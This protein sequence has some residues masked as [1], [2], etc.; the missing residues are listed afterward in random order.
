[1]KRRELLKRAGFLSTSVAVFGLSGCNSN[2][3]DD[4]GSSLLKKYRFPQGVVAADP[5]PDSIILWTRIVPPDYDDIQQ[6]PSTHAPINVTLEV[7]LSENFNEL[8]A[9]PITLQA[10]AQYDNTLR[11]K[12]TGLSAATTYYYRFRAEAG[13]SRVGRFKTAPAVNADVGSL[14]FAF[15]ACQDWSVNHWIGLS[16]LVKHN[17]DFVVH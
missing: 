8:T 2:D 1:M 11:H 4:V 7:S 14:N 9:T 15:M 16:A 3:D 10:Q 13:L 6:I 12:L 5:K 17:L